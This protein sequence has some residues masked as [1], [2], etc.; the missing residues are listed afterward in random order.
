MSTESNAVLTLV[1]RLWES[2]VA[3]SLTNEAARRIEELEAE[4]TRIKQP[5]GGAAICGMSDLPM[6]SKGYVLAVIHERIT[7]HTENL[8]GWREGDGYLCPTEPDLDERRRV[9]AHLSVAID[10]LTELKKA[11]ELE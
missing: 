9:R 11:L 3:S 7:W 8:A 10:V 2:D 4:L 6:I 1:E 5:I